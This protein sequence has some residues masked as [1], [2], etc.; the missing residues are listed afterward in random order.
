MT[1]HATI[2]ALVLAYIMPSYGVLK[3][4]ANARDSV[5]TPGLDRKSVV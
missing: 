2:L 5:N 1:S 4:L 3:R